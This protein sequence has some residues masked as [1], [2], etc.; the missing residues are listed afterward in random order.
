MRILITSIVDLK[1]TAHNRLHQFI[2]YLSK[3]HDIT[4]LSINDW[5]KATQTDT[6]LYFDCNKGVLDNIN[7]EYF[8]KQ[9]FSPILQEIASIII[10]KKVLDKINYKK[11]DIHFNYNS[12]VSGFFVTKKMKAINVATIYDVADDLPAMIRSSPQI[13]FFLR[14]VGGIVGNVTFKKNIKIADKVTAIN[15]TLKNYLKLPQ[16]KTRIIP[17]GVDT[18]I[19]VNNPSAQLKKQ[20][21]LDKA[22]TIGY[23]GVLREWVDLEPVYASVKELNNEKLDIR[24]LIVGEEGDLNKNKI[25]AQKYGVLDRSIFTG[26]IPYTQIPEYI[27]CMDVCL[28][29]FKL[30]MVSQNALPL[31]LFEYMACE[32]PVISTDLIG[33]REAVENRVLYASNSKE[34]KEKIYELLRNDELCRKMGLEGRKFVKENYSWQMICSKLEEILVKVAS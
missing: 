11:F 10:L 7:I 9:K 14:Y 19:F 15:C 32:K 16:A 17:N 28:L 20:L 13:P 8:T 2:K 22:F 18:E 5:W 30:D 24:L 1:K 25:L 29:P 4:V 27:S 26:T 12:L 6:K 23:V 31:K 3:N 21:G 34:F 33:T